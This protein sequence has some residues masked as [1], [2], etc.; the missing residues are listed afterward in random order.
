MARSRTQ[1]RKH[2]KGRSSQP[3]S[4]DLLLELG[5]E[6]L[7]FQFI[8]PSRG[9]LEKATAN[10]F[11]ELRLT[12]GTIRSFA[13]P[14]RLT[15]LV[16]ELADHQ[17][18][19]TK[20]SMGP[21]KSA[22]YDASG[23][24]TKAALGFAASQGVPVTALEVRQLPKGEYLFAVKREEGRTT[25][26]V[27]K[28][29]LAHVILQLSFPKAMKWNETG[30]RFAR[31][32]RW[33]LALYGDRI[34]RLEVGGVQSGNRTFGHRVLAG[35]PAAKGVTIDRASNYE[36]ALERAGVIVDPTRR[37]ALIEQQLNTLAQR[38]KGRWRTDEG[39][40]E[41]AV[42][43]VEFPSVIIG[44]F[45]PQFLELPADVIETAMR[46]HQ[47]FFA[48][49]ATSGDLL[50]KFMAVVNN[51]C[52]DM[53]LIRKGNERVLAARLS[54]AAF[55]YHEDQKTNLN[56]RAARLGTV[57]YH[58]KLGTMGQK[59]ERLEALAGWLAETLG[60]ASSVESARRAARLSKADL[61]TGVV[62]EFPALQ[63]IMGGV[64]AHRDGESTEVAAAIRDQYLP[65]GMDGN[66]P[67]TAVGK[68]VS[69]ADR[70]DTL[71]AF[72]RAG[73]IPKGSEDPFA[74]RRHAL[75]IVRIVIEGQLTLDLRKALDEARGLVKPHLTHAGDDLAKPLPFLLERFR[76][77][78]ATTSGIPADLIEAATSWAQA[79]PTLDLNDTMERIQAL[80]GIAKRLEFGPLVVGFKRAHRLVE[81]EQW[82]KDDIH[83]DAFQHE[84][85]RDLHAALMNVKAQMPAWLDGRH[86][87]DALNALVGLKPHIDAFFD[88]VMVNVEDRNLRAN[89]LSLLRVIDNL[90]MSVADFSVVLEQG[91]A[92]G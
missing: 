77:Y 11:N 61:L 1:P 50:P 22:A 19:A 3:A 65:R 70:L 87:S 82:T 16:E 12:H 33:I 73:M 63:G 51:R 92:G 54:D 34:I 75:S 88:G 72:F 45:D 85:E 91:A 17:S 86:Y 30:F 81:K 46:E 25:E 35:K 74:L 79:R 39:L 53:S 64:Y 13:T 40:L 43:A 21:P 23:Q 4:A 36:S 52:K 32:L 90:F 26:A 56:D 7:P 76:Y 47:G 68:I 69:L 9:V 58:Q 84:A 60:D 55:Y 28:E 29:H 62:G 2:P 44:D 57:I 89:R 5:T 14:R 66:V 49:R 83:L 24:P 80:H 27:L 67:E 78:V 48:L 42:Y 37:R 8:G 20:E 59:A 15:L 31:P 6:E 38:A 71:A 10:F 41:Q 18:A